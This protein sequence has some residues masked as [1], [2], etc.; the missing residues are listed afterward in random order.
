MSSIFSSNPRDLHLGDD[1]LAGLQGAQPEVALR[2]VLVQMGVA[3]EDVDHL[4][5]VALADLE[6]VEVVGR[7]DLHRAGALLGVGVFVGDDRDRSI[8]DRQH[9]VLADQLLVALVL[10]M[11]GNGGIAE[12]GLGARRADDDDG[13]FGSSFKRVLEVPHLAVDLALLDLQVRNRRVE[14]RVPVDQPLVL[15]DQP[16]LW[17][18]TNTV[19]TA[20]D[21][22]SSMVKRSRAQSTEVPRRRIWWV[23]LPPDSAFHSQTLLDEL[24]ATEIVPGLALRGELAL[25]HHLGGDAGMVGA[26]LPQGV[27]AAHPVEADQMS[28][29]VKLRAWPICRLPVTFGGG[30]TMV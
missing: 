1:L 25:D 22:P 28:C 10:G 26:G 30:I 13:A 20:S 3:V 16:C 11:D 14:D 17:R 15:V 8:D 5:A 7:R 4:Q 18:V 27:L 19:R 23:M 21:R 12:H 9:A 6:V 29:R 2:R 24:L